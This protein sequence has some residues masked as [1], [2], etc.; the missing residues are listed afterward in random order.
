MPH[1]VPRK[2]EETNTKIRHQLVGTKRPEGKFPK[3][4]I[5]ALPPSL[6]QFACSCKDFNI[7]EFNYTSNAGKKKNPKQFTKI[8][9]KWK[10]KTLI[11]F[12][13]EKT[14]QIT[15]HGVWS[16]GDS[17]SLSRSS[18]FRWLKKQNPLTTSFWMVGTYFEFRFHICLDL[19][20]STTF[21][22]VHKMGQ[23]FLKLIKLIY[24]LIVSCVFTYSINFIKNLCNKFVF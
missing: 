11:W 1:L 2:C 22:F 12:Q 14:K 16:P 15:F 17:F 13:I 20:I 4:T 24:V 3:F 5:W 7:P 18:G 21:F 23:V 8:N 10:P 19:G 9:Q 6:Q